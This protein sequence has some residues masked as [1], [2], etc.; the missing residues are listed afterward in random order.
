MAWHHASAPPSL[1]LCHTIAV[2]PNLCVCV[3]V[4]LLD[5]I[6]EHLDVI[7]AF[8]LL[9]HRKR[10]RLGPAFIPKPPPPPPLP[11]AG[12]QPSAALCPTPVAC[13]P[14]HALLPA[15]TCSA[16]SGAAGLGVGSG[17]AW[18]GHNT[19]E[20][21]VLRVVHVLRPNE[22]AVPRAPAQDSNDNS[23]MGGGSSSRPG[24][25]GPP[26]VVQSASSSS[27]AKSSRP[28]GSSMY[29][30]RAVG[31]AA[32]AASGMDS[33]NSLD[34]EE[35]LEMLLLVSR[36]WCAGSSRGSSAV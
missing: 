21:D 22:P 30:K 12:Q 23:S 10:G 16:S 32:A 5:N 29:G 26:L 33:I 31:R 36:C 17:C 1:R 13:T 14:Q 20:P 27:G 9:L 6:T 7:N 2:M 15:A 11:T 4:G 35:M 28:G 18:D 34:A 8:Q 19:P 25:P 24:S 3:Q